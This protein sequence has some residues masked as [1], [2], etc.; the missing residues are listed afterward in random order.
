M[1]GINGRIGSWTRKEATT[2]YEVEICCI[3][4]S[5]DHR[6]LQPE[7]VCSLD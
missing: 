5:T 3:F 6:S 7:F 4:S 1:P 2:K